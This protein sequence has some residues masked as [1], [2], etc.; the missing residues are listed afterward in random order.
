MVPRFKAEWNAK[1][2]S[3]A[4]SP[5]GRRSRSAKASNVNISLAGLSK[6]HVA[7]YEEKNKQKKRKNEMRVNQ[8]IDKPAF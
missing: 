2:K 4:L 3:A 7:A 8:C 5:I 1:R 6:K